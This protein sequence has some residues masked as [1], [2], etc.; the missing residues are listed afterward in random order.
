MQRVARCPLCGSERSFRLRSK[1]FDERSPDLWDMAL[2]LAKVPTPHTQHVRCCRV[3]GLA[4]RD[5]VWND[6][7]ID[8]FYSPETWS[9]IPKP[10]VTD[11]TIRNNVERRGG[12]RD[13]ICKH[14]QGDA[15]RRSIIDV[16]GRDG[17]SLRRSSMTGG[18]SRWRTSTRQ[19]RLMP[20]SR[21]CRTSRHR[22]CK[23]DSTPWW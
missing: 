8:L 16:G 4:Y 17:F 6:A 7:D 21:R 11:E 19:S 12:I 10:A 20:A 14:V 15:T 3:C 22:R 18:T 2:A 5:P 1:Q 9:L 13:V 23:V